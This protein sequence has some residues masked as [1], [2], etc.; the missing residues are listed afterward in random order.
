MK[1]RQRT[2]DGGT[3]LFWLDEED[4]IDPSTLE[5]IDRE[6]EEKLRCNYDHEKQ[7]L[8]RSAQFPSGD[9]RIRVK[10]KVREVENDEEN[11]D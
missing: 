3:R 1:E 9:G 5:V 6:R 10:Y 7:R 4:E 2:F 8:I 11:S